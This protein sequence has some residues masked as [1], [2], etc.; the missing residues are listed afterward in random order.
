MSPAG[1]VGF[2]MSPL[3]KALKDSGATVVR[4]TVGQDHALDL[5]VGS[6]QRL[7]EWNRTLSNQWSPVPPDRFAV[8]TMYDADMSEIGELTAANKTEYCRVHGYH[9]I[10]RTDGF[11][12]SRPVPWS[13]VRFLEQ[14]L[15]DHDW[16][17]WS[18]AD[19]LIM[20]HRTRLEELTHTTAD[21]I[22]TRDINGINSG[23]FLV[24]NCPW[25]HAF[26]AEVYAQTQYLHD[27]WW[28]NRAFFWLL[29]AHRHR[30]HAKIVRQEV[31]NS[32]LYE[33]SGVT[34]RR[35]FQPGDF[36]LHLPGLPSEL[37]LHLLREYAR[38]VTGLPQ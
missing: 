3:L 37:R 2:F 10:V 38:R 18:D 23:S 7:I 36:V 11:D 29:K 6:Q 4:R 13:K 8:L 19:S 12:A 30:R 20:N 5:L 25:A 1:P 14:H 17:F 22:I 33:A 27:R 28:E 21:L 35:S 9:C 34:G 26:L 24:R 16:V 15:P 31:L 32:Y